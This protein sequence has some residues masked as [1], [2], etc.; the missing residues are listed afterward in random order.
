MRSWTFLFH[1]FHMMIRIMPPPPYSLD[2][3]G[4]TP[5]HLRVFS[6]FHEFECNLVFI[7]LLGR[8]KE[9]GIGCFM[10]NSYVGGMGYAD[11]IKLLCPSLNGMQ[12]MVDIYVEYADDYNIT[13]NGSKSQIF[14]DDCLSIPGFPHISNMSIQGYFKGNVNS[15]VFQG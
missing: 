9:S 1:L 8:L 7:R 5:L 3:L 4:S 13:F 10:G 14:P 15:R 2:F 6:Y 12:Q 11:D